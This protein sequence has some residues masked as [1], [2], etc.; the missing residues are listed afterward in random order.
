MKGF[1]HF[2]MFTITCLFLSGL[3]MNVEAKGSDRITNKFDHTRKIQ[4]N[5][6]QKVNKSKKGKIKVIVQLE[7]KFTPE[8]RVS[9]SQKDKQE[10]NIQ[11]TQDAVIEDLDNKEQ[12]VSGH[13]SKFK[14]IP[15]MSME[16][17]EEGLKALAENPD[18][19]SIT[20]DAVISKSDIKTNSNFLEDK[21]RAKD[22]FTNSLMNAES[23]WSAGFTGKGKSV[24][25]L[26]T[27]VDR[28][29]PFLKG[30]VVYEACFSSNRNCDGKT[31]TTGEGAANDTEG[32]GT[33]VAGI[34]AGNTTNF[35]GVAKEA[36]ILAIK[37]LADKDGEGNFSD[38]LNGLERVYL[39][40]N[41]Y[42]ISAINMSLGGGKYS[43]TCDSSYTSI[44]NIVDNLKSAGIAT[45]AAS[46]NDSYKSAISAPACISS[47]VSVGSTNDYDQVS[48][49]SNSVS[50]LDLLAPGD[51]VYSSLPGGGYGYLSGTSMA[52]PQVTGGFALVRQK[53]PN[54][55]VDQIL[56]YMKEDGVSVKDKANN[57]PTPRLDFSWMRAI[58]I[59]LDRV[60]K[61]I[62]EGEIIEW[63]DVPNAFQ[64]E[65]E[66][67]KDNTIIY[68][69]RVDGTVHEIN[70]SSEM[71]SPG[72]YTVTVRAIGDG[73]HYQD[74]PV[75][76]Y[77]DTSKIIP[78]LKQVKKPIWD[79]NT[80]RWDEVTDASQYMIK[81]Y[82]GKT[83]IQTQTVQNN[84]QQYNLEKQ[85]V[86]P[87]S[88]TVTVQAIGDSVNY[89]DS[90]VSSPSEVNKKLTTLAKPQKPTWSGD[91]IHWKTVEHTKTVELRLYRGKTL[92][93]S[94]RVA[95][96]DRKYNLSSK[97]KNSGEYTVTIKA[98]GDNKSYKS[99]AASVHSDKKITLK[100]VPKPTWKGTVIQWQS[101]AKASKYELKL[102][103]GS[104]LVFTKHVTASNHKYSYAS[105]MKVRGT[106]TV[107]VEA[108]GN[109]K[110][111]RNGPISHRSVGK[112]R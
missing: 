41:Q 70:L 65:V 47:V 21:L 2:L 77:S 37:V 88:Y 62:L 39:L 54:S 97:M 30:K 6:E 83:L 78:T 67:Y 111:Y 52:T 38:L 43:S 34:A 81:L 63:T 17:D 27:G 24:A 92:I 60:Q 22:I 29:H 50:F 32:H 103:R 3:Q 51:P 1:K 10:S 7:E 94:K 40:R 12:D 48:S 98:I 46:G 93:L 20:E 89:R 31:A 57:I 86:K 36:N 105:K 96:G 108:I 87:G 99:G 66:L 53:Y 5:L 110:T 13:I 109:H 61:P 14:T 45:I 35:S 23:A 58:A 16:V 15:Y 59:T 19:K 106:Y 84:V 112:K 75:S 76:T 56:S 64:Y 73:A 55:T 18:V 25:I 100:Q 95:A 104:K 68:T 4:S 28:S 80:I 42:D 49:F 107:T 82:N 101:V 8:G 79:S 74:G 9:K 91:S 44:K 90:I 26:D 11:E 102:Y 33:H 72:S 71:E 85:M 69:T